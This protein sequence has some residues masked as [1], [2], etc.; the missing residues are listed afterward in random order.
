MSTTRE[1]FSSASVGLVKR[2]PG[3]YFTMGS[4]F[5]PREY[6]PRNIYVKEFDIAHAAVTVNQY[7]AFAESGKAQDKRWWSKEGWQWLQGSADGWGRENRTRPDAYEIQIRN[8]FHPVVGVTR[9]EAE[10]YCAWLSDQKKVVV[11]LPSEAEWEHAA[12]GEDGRPFP[13]GE[14]FDA[15]LANTFESDRMATV[16]AAS[17][18]GDV[19]PYEVR[20]MA[21]NV[22]EWTS[23]PYTPLA[24][25]VVASSVLFVV[26]GGSYNDTAYGARTAYRRAYPPGYFYPFLG[27]RVVVESR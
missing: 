25:E 1:L 21:G 11:R 15:S 3:G 23:S 7:A 27:F 18:E 2:I 4:R 24:D 17:I 10:A 6:P 20:D 16:D 12:R 9:F 22:Q 13:W 19:S 14:E 8:P 26:R 5:D